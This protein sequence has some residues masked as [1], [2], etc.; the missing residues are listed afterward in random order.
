MK[1]LF[2]AILLAGTF[3]TPIATATEP[4]NGS[5]ETDG[6]HIVWQDL[7][8]G[9]ELNPLRWD[10]EVNGTGGGNHELQ[11]YT[12]RSENVRLGDDGNGNGCLIITARRENYS[13]RNFT[14]GRINSKNRIAF[15]HGKL[16]A[17][18]KLPSTANGLWPAFWMMGNDYD[19][20]GW[21]KCGETDILEM[22]NSN[23][24]QS[25]TQARYF[26]G[27]CHWGQ[28]WPAASY[29]KST[30]K[31][32][33]L[34]DGEFHLFTLI[35]DENAIVMYVDLDKAPKQNP[36]YKLD[37]PAN[38]PDNVWSAGNYFHKPNFILFNLAVGGDFT[39]I[40]DAG[41]ITA[42]NEE[43]NN[44]AS[45]YV[46]YVKIYQKGLDNEELDAAEP[47][48]ESGITPSIAMEDS[49]DIRY[50]GDCISSDCPQMTVY[51]LS[52]TPVARTDTGEICTSAFAP[53]VYLASNIGTTRKILV[54]N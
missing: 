39:G 3:A 40:H 6:Y 21:P 36:Y 5:G 8:D 28:G 18:I 41:S 12:D 50:S 54:K 7:F 33:S 51:T 10:M 52:G 4:Q 43:N 20:V 37:C 38:E 2:T 1:H 49:F 24:I 45:M 9:T 26:N 46:N 30:T 29:A 42:L 11:Y 19:Q 22:G 13:G 27:A 23:G 48:D 17:S 35:W 14:S 32:Y 31:T 15:T 47:G 53:G 44:E 16:E 25:G 34:Q